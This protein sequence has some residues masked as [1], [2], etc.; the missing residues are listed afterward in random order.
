MKQ[1]SLKKTV[2]LAALIFLLPTLAMAYGGPGKGRGQYEPPQTAIDACDGKNTGDTVEFMNRRN[3]SISGTC[4]EENGLLI[5]MHEGGH[6]GNGY[7]MAGRP[8]CGN[9][10]NEWQGGDRQ[11]RHEMRAELLGLTEEQQEQIETIRTEEIAAHRDLREKMLEYREQMREL[12]NKGTFDESAV[13]TI[14]EE[15]AKI[16]VEMAVSRAEMR[17]KIHAI[18]TPEQQELAKN[19]SSERHNR[20]GSHHRGPGGGW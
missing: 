15:K 17:S 6:R 10:E 19:F 8:G 20:R 13:R 18:M 3:V 11:Y 12:T 4:Q 14:A 9:G 2:G 5:A 16:Q 7:G 1:N